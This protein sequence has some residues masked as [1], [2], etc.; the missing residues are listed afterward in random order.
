MLTI[1]CSFLAFHNPLGL[2]PFMGYRDMYSYKGYG[3]DQFWSEIGYFFHS[4]LALGI[5]F[6][7]PSQMFVQMEAISG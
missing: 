2:L 4:G 7:G 5:F 6:C 3:F 1:S